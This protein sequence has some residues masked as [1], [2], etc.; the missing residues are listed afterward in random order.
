[1]SELA[2]WN[3]ERLQ[4]DLS[5]LA[6]KVEKDTLYP[7]AAVDRLFEVLARSIPIDEKYYFSQYPDIQQAVEAG[8][9]SGA[10]QHYV[11]H[12]FYEDRLPCDILIDENDYLARYPDI[13]D[14]IKSGDV[15]SA[16]DHWLRFGRYEG[17]VAYLQRK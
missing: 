9:I 13:A 16:T 10:A 11:E 7:Q 1:M 8:E 4:K 12:G 14:G 5:R 6:I 15:E 17:R 2:V 3:F